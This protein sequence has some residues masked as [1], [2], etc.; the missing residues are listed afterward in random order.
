MKVTTSAK[1]YLVAAKNSVFTG[2]FTGKFAGKF[3]KK[4]TEKY[5]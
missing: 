3:S 4:V 1:F 2:E 5:D